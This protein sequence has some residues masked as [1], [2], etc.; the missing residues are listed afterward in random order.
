MRRPL[1]GWRLLLF[2]RCEHASR[3]DSDEWDGPIERDRWWAARLH[4][5]AC[6]PCRSEHRAFRWL[7]RMLAS[8]PPEHVRSE[9]AV[10]E[11]GL[12]PEAVER[13]GAALAEAR[14][15]EGDRKGP[16]NFPETL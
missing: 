2:A 1:R 9:Q 15:Q 16:E 6:R 4:R 8:A 11:R 14:V 5:L 12:S 13:I 3:A 7:R 10:Q